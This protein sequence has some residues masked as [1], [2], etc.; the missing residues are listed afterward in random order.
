VSEWV[1]APEKGLGAW[2]S[3]WETRVMGTSTA[4]SEGGRLG[5]KRWLTSGVRELARANAR[6]GG[7]R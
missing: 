4:D 2:G 3:G 6:T 7:H 5:K 1:R